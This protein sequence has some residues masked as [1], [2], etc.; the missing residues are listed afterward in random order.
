MKDFFEELTQEELDAYQ[1]PRRAK[2]FQ[3]G[4]RISKGASRRSI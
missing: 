4:D 3:D 2:G 1:A